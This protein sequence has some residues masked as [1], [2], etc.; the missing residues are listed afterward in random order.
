MHWAIMHEFK[1]EEPYTNVSFLGH[2]CYVTH[3]VM[4]AVPN[5]ANPAKTGDGV[6]RTKHAT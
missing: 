6:L 2:L 3:G 1:L 4:Q 5:T